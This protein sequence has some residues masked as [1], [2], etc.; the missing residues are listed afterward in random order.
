MLAQ[1]CQGYELQDLSPE[2]LK[3]AGICTDFDAMLDTLND[4]RLDGYTT[5]KEFIEAS[6]ERDLRLRETKHLL[7]LLKLQNLARMDAGTPVKLQEGICSELDELTDTLLRTSTSRILR[8]EAERKRLEKT[9]LRSL[10]SALQALG[11]STDE[12][13]K[14]I[15][16]QGCSK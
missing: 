7:S 2:M 9:P 15:R 10:Y 8:A 3:T 4:E 16:A 11:I 5:S 6:N 14:A 12:T 13:L 1:T